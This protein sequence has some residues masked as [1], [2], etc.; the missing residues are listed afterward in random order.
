LPRA[1]SG[2][3]GV[4]NRRGSGT[5]HDVPSG[6]RPLRAVVDP[7]AGPRS[8]SWRLPRAPSRARRRG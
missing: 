1:P 4:V 3:V 5:G 2:L 8:S 6:A 7:R